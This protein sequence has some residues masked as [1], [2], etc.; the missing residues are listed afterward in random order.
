MRDLAICSMPRAARRM[1]R[2]QYALAEA[3]WRI[4][5]P[6]PKNLAR[7]LADRGEKVAEAVVIAE[8]AAR[9]R[10]DIFTE[11]AL[12]WA[13]FKAGRVEDAKRAI[14]LALRTGTRDRD[15]LR[16]AEAIG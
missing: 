2:E 3:A 8:E 14:R 15:I 4:D 9:V 13:Y 6:E 12:A 5:A 7:F 16:H 11:D 1:R 10:H